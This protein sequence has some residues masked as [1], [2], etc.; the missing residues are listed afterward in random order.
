MPIDSGPDPSSSRVPIID[1]LRG[2]VL[3]A[4]FAALGWVLLTRYTSSGRFGPVR[5]QIQAFFKAAHTGDSA[6][7]RTLVSAEEPLR[8]AMAEAARVPSI[9]PA[10]DSALQVRGVQQRG[11]TEAVV[12]WVVGA[13]SGQ[14]FFVTLVGQGRQ[15]RI[16]SVSSDCVPA[17]SPDSATKR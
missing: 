7:L 8:W 17:R 2:A 5:R 6:R 4:G 12:V 16:Q 10:P 13:C 1:W 3:V 11:D 9:L 15:R 14:P